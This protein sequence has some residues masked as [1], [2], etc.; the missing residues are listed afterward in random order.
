MSEVAQSSYVS[1][2]KRRKVLNFFKARMLGSLKNN[3]PKIVSLWKIF[4]KKLEKIQFGKEFEKIEIELAPLRKKVL[5]G[6]ETSAQTS[7]KVD[8]TA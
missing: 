1:F 5:L 7:E 3:K 2:E 6:V 8:V 4:I